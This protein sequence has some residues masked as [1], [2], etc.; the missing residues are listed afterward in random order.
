MVK[1][2]VLHILVDLAK[3]MRDT[4]IKLWNSNLTKHCNAVPFQIQIQILFLLSINFSYHFRETG[5]KNGI[6]KFYFNL[7]LS[8]VNFK[9]FYGCRF[10]CAY[11]TMPLF[12]L[13]EP[14]C[15]C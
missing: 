5:E 11:K 6:I 10:M 13:F 15:T 1:M 7:I 14:T 9:S 2:T 4:V 12:H 8:K 3:Y